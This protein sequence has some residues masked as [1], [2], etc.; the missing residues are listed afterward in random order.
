MATHRPTGKKRGA[1]GVFS[2]ER[3]RSRH[4]HT[5]TRALGVVLDGCYIPR[6]LLD[7]ADYATPAFNNEAAGRQ[8]YKR[9]LQLS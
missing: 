7:Q 2:V 5:H 4:A 6:F 8:P 1:P 3:E 9:A